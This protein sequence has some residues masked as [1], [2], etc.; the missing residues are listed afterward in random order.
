VGPPWEEFM[1]YHRLSG[2]VLAGTALLLVPSAA[3]A[4]RQPAQP[5]ADARL[6]IEYNA[7]DGD[8]GFQIFADAEEWKRF[9]IFTPDGRKLVDLRAKGVLR[10][11]GLSELFSESSEPPFDELPFDQFKQLF[12]EGNYRFEGKTVDGRELRSTVPF[13]HR[14]L[15]A[16]QFIQP[17]DDGTLPA[18]HAVIRWAPVRGA[19]DY[20]IIVTSED[21]QRIVDVTMSPDDTSL[22]VPPQFLDVGADYQIEVHAS[23]VSSN[24]IF[25]EVGFTAT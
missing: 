4:H 12:P 16:P 8:A 23:D 22:T 1:R 17:Q 19:V 11:F 2:F 3:Q 24:R 9:E 6:E 5:F 10:D 21:E 7:T 13:S 15:A 25:T 20:E 14:V 18:R